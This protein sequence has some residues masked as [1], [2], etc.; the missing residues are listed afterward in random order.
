MKTLLTLLIVLGFII[1]PIVTLFFGAIFLYVKAIMYSVDKT[2]GR[3]NG[4]N[5]ISFNNINYSTPYASFTN[6]RNSSFFNTN[7]LNNWEDFAPI[8][9]FPEAE[10]LHL[11]EK[12]EQQFKMI[13]RNSF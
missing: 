12:T 5:K 13:I 4:G 9:S 1:I 8:I 6:N 7:Y 10:K 2:L 11:D 3:I